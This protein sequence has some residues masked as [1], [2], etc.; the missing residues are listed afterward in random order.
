[1]RPCQSE[2][3]EALAAKEDQELLFLKRANKIAQSMSQMLIDVKFPNAN[4]GEGKASGVSY[5]DRR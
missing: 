1:M 4:V 3:E 2:Y 5:G